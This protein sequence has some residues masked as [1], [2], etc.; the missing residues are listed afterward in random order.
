MVCQVL[1]VILVNS[2]KCSFKNV[3]C[4]CSPDNWLPLESGASVYLYSQLLAV[5]SLSSSNYTHL[6]PWE[7]WL[8]NICDSQFRNAPTMCPS[9]VLLPNRDK[10]KFTYHLTRTPVYPLFCMG[11]NFVSHPW[12]RKQTEDE[13]S[14]LRVRTR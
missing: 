2:N 7:K 10:L 3:L 8:E 4:A 11:V 9:G 14:V 12:G 13:K 5:T 6:C 1:A